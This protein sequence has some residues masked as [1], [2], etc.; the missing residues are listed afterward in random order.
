MKSLKIELTNVLS[1]DFSSIRENLKQ[2]ELKTEGIETSI[3][4]GCENDW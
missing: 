1:R 3:E 4:N 2:L